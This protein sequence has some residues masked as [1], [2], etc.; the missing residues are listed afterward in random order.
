MTERC[1]HD[2][3]YDR[4]SGP[5]GCNLIAHDLACVC[6]WRHSMDDQSSG[7]DLTRSFLH[8]CQRDGVTGV[9]IM[10]AIGNAAVGYFMTETFESRTDRMTE[11]KSWCSTLCREV[12]SASDAVSGPGERGNG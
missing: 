11:V 9:A 7:V 3:G 4:E 8:I 5:L 12:E 6:Q 2:M 1:P 10:N